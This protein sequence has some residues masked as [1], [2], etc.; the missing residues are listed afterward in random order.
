[1]RVIPFALAWDCLDHNRPHTS[2]SSALPFIAHSS[3]RS[4]CPSYTAAGWIPPR[5]AHR[6]GCGPLH[7]KRGPRVT[8]ASSEAARLYVPLPW[9]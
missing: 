1:V 3:F 9:W 2:A 5:I 7:V 4:I 8:E 6:Q